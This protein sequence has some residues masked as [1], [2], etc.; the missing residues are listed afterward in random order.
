MAQ[1]ALQHGYRKTHVV[2][3]YRQ[4][5]AINERYL[6]QVESALKTLFRDFNLRLKKDFTSEV[7]RITST[8]WEYE[9][10]FG[11]PG[12]QA[13]PAAPAGAAPEDDMA[14]K[15]A[16]FLKRARRFAKN[17][18]EIDEKEQAQLEKLAEELGIPASAWKSSSKT[19][20]TIEHEGGGYTAPF[21]SAL[22]A[23][24]KRQS[25]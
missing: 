4:D 20:S 1:T 19:P 6:S 9:V 24:K 14:R 2:L 21:P 23:S 3:E 18:G 11:D 5:Y 25:R 13:R 22:L 12:V 16:L 8:T 15:E 7:K 17:D 10:D